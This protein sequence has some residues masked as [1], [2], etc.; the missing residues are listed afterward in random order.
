MN[1]L[2]SYLVNYVKRALTFKRRVVGAVPDYNFSKHITH[3]Q[4][5][6]HGQN[7][8]NIEN[9]NFSFFFE[10][11]HI[12]MNLYLVN[13]LKFSPTFKTRYVAIV[14]DYNFYKFTTDKQFHFHGEKTFYFG[15]KIRKV[16]NVDIKPFS[17][18]FR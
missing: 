18:F 14:P 13:Y 10:A 9:S 8:E 7:V 2:D 5:R 3:K 15:K 4:L 6:F 1:I 17:I 12:S 11:M 16:K